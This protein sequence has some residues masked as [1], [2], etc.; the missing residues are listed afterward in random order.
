MKDLVFYVVVLC[1]ITVSGFAPGGVSWHPV[2]SCSK[3]SGMKGRYARCL[4]ESVGKEGTE[5]E[6]VWEQVQAL[7]PKANIATIKLKEHKPL[8]LTIEESLDTN[9][10]PS[11]VFVSKLVQ[12]GNAE[13]G[14]ILLGDVLVGA[15][16]L[17]ED[18]TS[19]WQSGVDKMYVQTIVFFSPRR[20]DVLLDPYR[21]SL[22]M[23]SKPHSKGL[24]SSVPED[25]ILE[26]RVARNTGVME[27]HEAFVV[28]MCQTP[29]ASDKEVQD[30]LV[31]FLSAGYD[32]PSSMMV[33]DDIDEECSLDDDDADCLLNS[34]MDMW[35]DEL[36][37][38]ST[39]SGSADSGTSTSSSKP[40]PWSSRSSPSGTWV[41]D[42]VTGE[43]K[44][45]D[46]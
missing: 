42:P 28:E 12:G 24:V 35:A 44:N 18:V 21:F 1:G 45:I 46:A 25:D 22:S 38:S 7:Y 41:R 14:G 27:R 39:T 40:K 9:N 43:M 20:C 31:T 30:C 33:E 3:T 6:V 11:V 13:K 36:P 34:M 2:V 29:G 5:L 32:S 10:D 8:G 17:F 26:L 19:T 4:A 23:K 16:G 15:T 37:T